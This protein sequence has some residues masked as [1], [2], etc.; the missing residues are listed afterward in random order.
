MQLSLPSIESLL[1][2]QKDSFLK[3]GWND[4]QPIHQVVSPYRICP[5]GAHVDHQGGKVLGRTINAYSLLTFSVDE[6]NGGR[7]RSL[8][9]E[10]EE[11]FSLNHKAAKAQT[12]WGRYLHGA[13]DV[14]KKAYP[15]KN[16]IN[17][18]VMGT[19]PGGGLSSSASVGLAYLHA[20]AFA[21]RIELAPWEMIELDRQLENDYLGL[22]NGI[23]DQSM[24]ALGRAGEMLYLDARTHDHAWVPDPAASQE[25]SFL[26]VYSGFSRALVS[27]G[28]NDRVGEC[29]RAAG[30]LGEMVGIEEAGILSDVPLEVYEEN[31]HKLPE[32]LGKRATHYYSEVDRVEQGRLAWQ[33]GDMQTFGGLMNASCHSSITQYESGFE[34]IIRLHEI[35][36]GTGGVLGSRF[37][38]GGYGGC[39]I[40]LVEN[41]KMEQAAGEIREA[42]LRLY[43]EMEDE[44]LLFVVKD[45]GGVQVV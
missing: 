42:Y 25:Y 24:I 12:S 45:E 7:I 9:F 6:S 30:L 37:G 31:R 33:T 28:F 2:Q 18:L 26:I 8:E 16:K 23:L 4:G 39:V 17:G 15:L 27:T 21:N 10:G 3:L 36:S 19:L 13:V 29:R 35:A 14:L 38:G 32:D 22:A 41:E 44:I 11:T 1:A 43:P 34:P 40:G 5:L 20:L